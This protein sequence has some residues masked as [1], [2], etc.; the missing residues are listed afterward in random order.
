[1]RFQPGLISHIAS[2]AKIQL[3]EISAVYTSKDAKEQE[4]QQFKSMPVL[5]VQVSM[6]MRRNKD[7]HST[8]LVVSDLEQDQFARPKWI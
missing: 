4:W 8:Y 7:M 1:M 6:L 2:P 5:C 3:R